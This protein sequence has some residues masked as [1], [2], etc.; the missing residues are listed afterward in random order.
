MWFDFYAPRTE[1]IGFHTGGWCGTRTFVGIL[2]ILRITSRDLGIGRIFLLSR[3]DSCT[4]STRN[5]FSS[6]TPVRMYMYIL[7]HRLNL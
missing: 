4:G 1:V 5:C 3:G 2:H 6:A 7:L